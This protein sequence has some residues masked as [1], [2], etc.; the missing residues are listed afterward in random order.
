MSEESRYMLIDNSLGGS[1]SVI[2]I[3]NEMP[4]ILFQSKEQATEF[5]NHL[6]Q[7]ENEITRL[8][9]E[10]KD[11]N[12]AFDEIANISLRAYES[13]DRNPYLKQIGKVKLYNR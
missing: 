3:E 8:K 11:L 10:N 13:G 12:D 4:T 6:Q 1:C 7:Q 2:D 5:I 9:E